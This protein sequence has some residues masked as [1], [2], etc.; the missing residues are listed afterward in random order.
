VE[1]QADPVRRRKSAFLNTE[2]AEEAELGLLSSASL[3]ETTLLPSSRPMGS[4]D[5]A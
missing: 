2:E 1:A 3:R 4:T 5:R